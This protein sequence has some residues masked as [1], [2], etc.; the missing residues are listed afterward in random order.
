MTD[1]LLTA[2]CSSVTGGIIALTGVLLTNRSSTARLTIQLDHEAESRKA[3][4]L[5]ERGE[6]LYVLMQNWLTFFANHY[7][8]L[9]QVM[10]G[11]LTYNQ[12][13]DLEIEAANHNPMEF[14]RIELL[15]D[16]YYPSARQAYDA[17]MARRADIV[18]IEGA[19]HRAYQAGDTDGTRFLK[20][21]VQAQKAVEAAGETFK[22]ELTKAI[23]TI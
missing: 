22:V 7:L 19:H 16:I 15:I 11:S 23:Q 13:L 5:R 4:T 3:Q 10:K 9:S 20:A 14:P 1:Q 17:I 8:R 12:F 21:Y 6:E 18:K 2:L